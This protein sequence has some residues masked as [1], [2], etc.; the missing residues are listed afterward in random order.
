MDTPGVNII[1]V[2][3][4]VKRECINEFISVTCDHC[5]ACM[6]G[7]E[8]GNRDEDRDI[9]RMD[10]IQSALERDRF[11][12]FIYASEEEAFKNHRQSKEYQL[13]SDTVGSMCRE[14]RESRRLVSVFPEKRLMPFFSS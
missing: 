10:F 3:I 14:P 4:A 5:E 8:D 2:D 12:I 9:L 7:L 13:W 11:K 1:C 6:N